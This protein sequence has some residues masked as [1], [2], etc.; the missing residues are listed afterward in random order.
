MP[1]KSWYREGLYFECTQCGEC[2]TWTGGEV[3]VSVDEVRA[4][5][6]HLGITFAQFRNRYTR[7]VTGRGRCLVEKPGSC[8]FFDDE[9]GCTVYEHRPRQCRTFP[10]WRY[11]LKSRRRWESMAESCEGMNEGRW[12]SELNILSLASRDGLYGSG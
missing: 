5:A 8:V 7:V 9:A 2:C 6:K 12:H 3:W 4:L 10:F 11:N 1:K